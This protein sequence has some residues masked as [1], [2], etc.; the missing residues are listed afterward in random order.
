MPKIKNMNTSLSAYIDYSTGVKVSD[1]I[2][3]YKVRVM[4]EGANRN[5]S[6]FTKEVIDSMAGRIG[7]TP[8]I[9]HYS[10]SAQDF[11]AHG[12]LVVSVTEDGIETKKVGP[13]PYG[14]VAPDAPTWFEENL[15]PDGVTRNYLTTE[16]LLWTGRFPELEILSEG[17]NNQSMEI[18]PSTFKG[19]F[20]EIDGE[21]L[22]FV[23]HADFSGLCILG[24]GIEPCF[25]GAGISNTYSLETRNH[26][27]ENL[28]AMKQEL[29]KTNFSLDSG[30]EEEMNKDKETEVVE[31]VVTEEL[32]DEVTE[33]VETVT[34]E[35]SSVEHNQDPEEEVEVDEEIN[36]DTIDTIEGPTDEE[37]QE[38]ENEAE[39]EENNDEDINFDIDD[40]NSL[41]EEYTALVAER[42]ELQ[43][44]LNVYI[45][46]E[47][48][49]E[50][51]TVLEAYDTIPAE[52]REAIMNELDD[53]TLEQ[54]DYRALKA[55]HDFM[56]EQQ[57][58]IIEKQDENNTEVVKDFTL[59]IPDEEVRTVDSEQPAWLQ[60]AKEKENK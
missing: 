28:S 51:V 37:L 6:Y 29:A 36:E 17:R 27:V 4:Y 23:E 34:E 2:T 42:D 40:Y 13:T 22:Y 35:N 45:H 30:E 56:K 49:A 19:H 50:K 25:E 52:A 1:L 15:D 3:K 41:H 18:D 54:V 14:F 9:G 8:V 5:L 48:R 59:D 33:V 47:E 11:L 10:E 26:F 16:V 39:E 7:G 55:S 31:E 20:A 57:S 24:Q 38:I 58:L 46:A 44:R 21:D 12:D 43:D 32:Q 53:L 60:I